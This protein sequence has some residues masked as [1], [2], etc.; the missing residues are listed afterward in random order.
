MVFFGGAG[1]TGALLVP[2]RAF[3]GP[4]LAQSPCLVLGGPLGVQGAIGASPGLSGTSISACPELFLGGF[5][6]VLVMRQ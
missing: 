2:D 4:L 6:K 3:G 5:L 1:G